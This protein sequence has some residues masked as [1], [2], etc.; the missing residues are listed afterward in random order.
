MMPKDTPRRTR[1]RGYTLIEVMMAIGIMTV[2]AVGLM[3]LQTAATMANLESHHISIATQSTRSWL[4]RLKRDGLNWVELGPDG[5]TNNSANLQYLDSVST[6][7][8]TAAGSWVSLTPT[9]TAES[10]AFDFRGYDTR[11]S[12]D[13]VYCSNVRLVWTLNQ[14]A[15]RADVRTWWHRYSRSGRADYVD[16]SAYSCSAGNQ[17]LGITTELTGAG[18]LR[19]VTAS[20]LIRPTETGS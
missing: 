1:N 7:P 19:S 2:G 18:R 17:D 11:T 4:E 5:L 12:A 9:S 6:L 8:A 15:L 16:L 10:W 20:T 13:I 14:N 3:S